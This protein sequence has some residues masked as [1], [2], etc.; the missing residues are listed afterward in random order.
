MSI[1]FFQKTYDLIKSMKSPEW[2]KTL[3]YFLLHNVII[4]SL[5]KMGQAAVLQLENTIRYAAEQDWDNEEK[6]K[7]VWDTMRKSYSK[8]EIKDN[9]LNLGIELILAMLKKK[10][11]IQ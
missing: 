8:D 5:L 2:F 6:Y 3:T 7:Y 9:I 4:P 1:S 11:V 10:G